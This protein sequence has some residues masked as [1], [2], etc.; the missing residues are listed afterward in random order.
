MMLEELL[1]TKFV[2]VNHAFES[3]L[4]VVWIRE[5]ENQMGFKVLFRVV[6]HVQ[7]FNGARVQG[8]KGGKRQETGR[9]RQTETETGQ[10]G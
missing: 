4:G 10:R 9:T 1:E 8:F 6:T 3:R 2:T 7:R 5:R